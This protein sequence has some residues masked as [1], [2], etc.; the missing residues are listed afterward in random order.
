MIHLSVCRLRPRKAHASQKMAAQDLE[1]LRTRHPPFVLPGDSPAERAEKNA[2]AHRAT[3][4]II[5]RIDAKN[6]A[7]PKKSKPA[8]DKN[9][10]RHASCW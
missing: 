2:A 7:G 4:E 10:V 3:L 1:A 6:G 5:E 8:S 9:K